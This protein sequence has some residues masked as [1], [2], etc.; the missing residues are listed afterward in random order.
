VFDLILELVCKFTG[1]EVGH[2]FMPSG[3]TGT[4]LQSTKCWYFADPE[5]FLL[6]KEKSEHL[7]FEKNIGFPGKVCASAEPIWIDNLAGEPNNLRA[8]A[9]RRVGIKGSVFQPVL[10]LDKVVAVVEFFTTREMEHRSDVAEILSHV[11]TQMGRVIERARAENS[12]IAHRDKLQGRVNAA[13]LDL[14]TKA[15]ELQDALVKERELT[16]LQRQF[17][18]MTSHEFRTPL[19]IIDSSVHRLEKNPERLTPENIAKRLEKIRR[20]V[21][22]MTRLMESTLSAFQMDAGKIDVKLDDCDLAEIVGQVLDRQRDISHQPTITQNL[23]ALPKNIRGDGALLDQVFTNLL[24]NAVKFSPPD[25][26]ILVKGWLEN[27]E[28]FISVTDQGIGIDPEDMS[29]MFNRYFRAKSSTGIAGTGIGLNLARML[30]H[31]HGGDIKL[32]S[33]IGV[34]SIFTVHL[35]LVPTQ[36]KLATEMEAA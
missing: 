14:K 30:V 12:L 34:G 19:A 21:T 25:S 7:K 31:E 6:F 17:V 13:T 4:A 11:T 33:T 28:A 29:N 26:T 10:L 3:G 22:R 27:D 18:S 8:L 9:A 23:T 35:P 24:S 36:Q 15:D 20:A 2:V 32:E 1:W 16:E 5:K